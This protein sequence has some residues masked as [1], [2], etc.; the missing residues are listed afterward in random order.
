MIGV[1]RSTYYKHLRHRLSCRPQENKEGVCQNLLSQKF[2]QK[3][4]NLV[5]VCDFIYVEV[6][7]KFYYVCAILDLDAQKVIAGRVDKKMDRF[8]AIDTQRDAN[9]SSCP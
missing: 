3:A 6:A 9:A 7:G 2:D 4:P 1:N 5:W 8:L